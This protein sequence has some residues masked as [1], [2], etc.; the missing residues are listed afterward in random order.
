[1]DAAKNVLA[2]EQRLSAFENAWTPP[3]ASPDASWFPEQVGEWKRTTQGESTGIARLHIE[4]AGRSGEY[5]FGAE[6][7]EVNVMAANDSEKHELFS[8]AQTGPSG[9]GTTVSSWTGNR[10]Y[11]RLNGDD[12][13]RC[14]WMPKGWFFIFH[15]RGGDPKEF[16]ESYL[17]AIDAAP[18]ATEPAPAL[19]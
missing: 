17:K 6:V 8:S 4:R 13:T 15:S 16:V 14:W 11:L 5:R 3:S 7:V 10:S 9:G 19:K 12:Y 2:E 1:V 18:A